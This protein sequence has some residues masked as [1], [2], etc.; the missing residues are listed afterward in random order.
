MP[1]KSTIH[2]SLPAFS[3]P[4]GRPVP[5]PPRRLEPDE[6]ASQSPVLVAFQRLGETVRELREYRAAFL[7]LLAALVY[8]E[9]IGTIYKLAAVY[10]ADLNLQTSAL[11]IAILLTQ[12]VG[13]PFAVLFGKLAKRVGPRSAIMLALAIYAGICA[14]AYFLRTE[15]QFFVLAIG[16]GMVQ[17][18]AQALTRSLFA[19]LI[20][21]HKSAEFFGL[22]A[23][24]SKIAGFFGLAVFFAVGSLA[25]S[26]RPAVLALVG[27]FA[28]GALLLSR[29]DVKA[30]RAVARRV[31]QG[32]LDEERA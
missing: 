18:G 9:G 3:I 17:G 28:L 24:A 6:R 22:F 13:V 7:M 10:G 16:V 11:I 21:Q 30:G 14:Y 25:G 29:V 15:T 2:A 5:E 32:L 12:F 31:E 1:S 20:P 4:L 23:F 26:N 19:S 8:G 27:F